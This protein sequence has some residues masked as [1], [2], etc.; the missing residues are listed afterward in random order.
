MTFQYEFSQLSIFFGLILGH[1]ISE[2]DRMLAA[3]DFETAARQLVPSVSAKDLSSYRE[4]ER[5]I[6]QSSQ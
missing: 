3:I 6:N 5:K 2:G 4:L 1:M